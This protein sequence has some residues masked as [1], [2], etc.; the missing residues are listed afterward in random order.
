MRNGWTLRFLCEFGGSG[1][2]G[3]STIIKVCCNEREVGQEPGVS[4]EDQC[5]GNMLGED[6]PQ[7][8]AKAS[9][10]NCL[11]YGGIVA[12]LLQW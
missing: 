2:V 12:S 10:L 5:K 6:R 1:S 8:W 9:D 11:D 3:K 4:I 7:G